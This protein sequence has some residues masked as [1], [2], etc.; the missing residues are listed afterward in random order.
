M[1][2]QVYWR[3]NEARI[4]A[5]SNVSSNY[6]DPEAPDRLAD[7]PELRRLVQETSHIL[8]ANERA[9]AAK[10]L[11]QRLREESYELSVGYTNIPWGVGPRV[12][13]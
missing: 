11:Y 6:A 2:G 7:D 4:D 8:D 10:K 1:K 5:A 9:E 12:L 13:T 3:D